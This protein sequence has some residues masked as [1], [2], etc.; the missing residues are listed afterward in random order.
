MSSTEILTPALLRAW[1]LP[2]GGTSKDARGAVLVIGGARATPGAAMLAGLAALRV[3]AGR[4]TL[5]VAA[6][7]AP[8]VAV[9]V[10]E[11]GGFGL[12]ETPAGLLDGKGVPGLSDELGRAS[13]VLIGP[14][15]DGAQETQDLLEVVLPRVADDCAVVLD[16][17]ALGVLR[18]LERPLV[19]RL[20]GR[21]VLTP[22]T[23]EAARLLGRDPSGDPGDP[24]GLAREIAAA[25]GAVVS[26]CGALADASGRSWQASTGSSGLATSGSGDVLAGAVAG[27]LAGGADTA[28]ATCWGT[29]LHG[30]AGDRLAARVARHGYLARELLDELPAVLTELES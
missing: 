8:A 4:L 25:Y 9:A 16:A 7:V 27:V 14:G 12:P 20:E 15:L 26:C 28:Q 24:G 3:G 1:P 10:P 19:R 30:A 22:N 21:L 11:A 13:V 29:H 6:S 18:D 2:D 5:A 17:F 23:S